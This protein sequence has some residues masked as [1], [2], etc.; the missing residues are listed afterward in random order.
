MTAQELAL[1]L[2]GRT[3]AVLGSGI[4]NITPSSNYHVARRIIE[5]GQGAV[6]SSYEPDEK[7]SKITF[8]QRDY[9]MAAMSQAVL[10]IE[11]G[12]RSGTSYTVDAALELGREVFAVPGSIFSEFSMGCHKYIKE[13]AHLVTSSEDI[14]EILG[15]AS[16]DLPLKILDPKFSS[17]TEKLVFDS[18][19]E[20]SA[21]MNEICLRVN[22]PISN[23]LQ[24]ASM[25]ELKGLVRVK[26]NIVEL[27]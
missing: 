21:D 26:G 18:A 24:A 8:P 12:E 13:G 7:A 9:P 15:V 20:G 16:T 6:I 19:R 4:N 2:G 17:E 3:L 23:I 10:V 5:S 27:L 14:F 22:K 25:L 1:D 11:A